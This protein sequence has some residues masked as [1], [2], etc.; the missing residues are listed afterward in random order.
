[1]LFHKLVCIRFLAFLVSFGFVANLTGWELPLEVEEYCGVDGPRPVTI[2]IPL[3]QGQAQDIK[4][5]SLSLVGPDG[6]KMVLPSQFRELARWWRGDNSIRW[7]LADFPIDINSKEKK[8]VVLSNTPGKK[9]SSRLSA[10]SDDNFITVVT[11]PAKF[12]IN[13]KKFN[14]FEKVIVDIN[15]DGKLSD[16][17]NL[18]ATTV[19]CGTVTEDAFGQKYPSSAGTRSVEILEAGAQ[20]VCVRARGNHVAPEGK[21]Y[22]PGL[23]TYDVFLNF[24]AENTDVYTDT[25]IC[26]N[27]ATSIGIPSMEDGSLFI[28]LA[29]GATDFVLLG[30]EPVQGKLAAGQTVCLYQDSNGADTWEI[31]PGF[32]KMS[33]SGWSKIKD[34][35]TSFRGYRVTRSSGSDQ[36]EVIG[37]GD[38]ARGT[39]QAWNQRGGVVV[40]VKNFWQQFPKAAEVS[41]DGTIRIGL[42]PREWKWPHMIQDGAAK[43]YEVIFHFYGAKGSPGK[44]ANDGQMAQAKSFADRWDARVFARPPAEHRAATGA[45]ADLGP[46]TIPTKGVTKK[47]DTRTAAECSRMLTDDK[48]YGNA[49]GWRVFGERWR[50]NGGH[51]SLGARQPIDEDNYLWLWYGGGLFDWLKAGDNRSRHFRDVR[52]YR[53]DDVD[54]LAF[55]NWAEFR[56]ANIS[57]RDEW[58]RRPQ[59]T[60]EEANKY[61]HGLPGYSSGWSYPNPEHYTLDLLYDRYLLFGD[62]RSFENMRIAAGFGAFFARDY[63]PKP[64]ATL[65]QICPTVSR[66]RGW[67]WRTLERYWE[68]TGDKRADELLRE[69]IKAYEPL[70]GKTGLWFAAKEYQREWFAQVFSRA[71]AMTALHTNDP[72]ALEICRALASDKESHSVQFATVIAVTYHLTGEEKY[73]NMIA[74]HLDG[75]SLLTLGGYFP[76]C[77]HWLLTHPPRK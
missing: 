44:Y 54:A 8:T 49:Y 21:G 75:D 53:I 17:E 76:A 50:S 71:A 43:G 10:T 24:Y 3:L 59:P 72:T 73:K 34:Q 52:R 61:Q 19:A 9:P 66:D 68:L 32:G 7:V 2:G 37:Q 33:G 45:L 38:H 41:G 25:V 1:M 69:I 55:K 60:S 15:G 16:D 47:P 42:W 39:L 65:E 36:S 28:K 57:E 14:F 35:L 77:D 6:K 23:Y 56:Q 74:K 51:G 22:T 29:G 18:L 26:N 58:T 13:R 48:L 12:V 30:Q 64:G 46:Y 5:L 20:R 67:A 70:I 11:G 62:M 31:C 27:Y 40:H 63:A 4:S